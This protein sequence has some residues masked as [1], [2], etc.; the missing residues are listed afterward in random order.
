MSIPSWLLGR[1]VTAVR[2]RVQTVDVSGTLTPSGAP[3]T[4]DQADVVLT[5]GS[6]SAQ[7]IAFTNGFLNSIRLVGRK[8]TDNISPTNRDKANYVPLRVGYTITVEEVLRT[9]ADN[10]LLANLWFRGATRYVQFDFALGGN[11]WSD[12]YLMTSYTEALQGGK[13]TGVMT[14][15]SV[16]AGGGTYSAADR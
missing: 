8:S 4:N 14:L 10:C 13:N 9:G 3:G 12:V 7:T 5:T 1:H 11:K 6:S 16:D 15:M 2:A